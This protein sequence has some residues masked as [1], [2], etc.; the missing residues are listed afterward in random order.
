E[1]DAEDLHWSGHWDKL[2][3]DSENANNIPEKWETDNI[4]AVNLPVLPQK[5]AQMGKMTVAQNISEKN[6]FNRT[7]GLCK[8]EKFDLLEHV[9]NEFADDESVLVD[10][11]SN[12]N[13]VLRKKPD[14]VIISSGIGFSVAYEAIDFLGLWNRIRL[15]KLGF[16]YPL[17]VH[18]L[19]ENIAD[20]EKILIVEDT[21]SFI[22]TEVRSIFV[23][24]DKKWFG[25]FNGIIDEID[26]LNPDSMVEILKKILNADSLENV[27]EIVPGKD[28]DSSEN[29]K[30][31]SELPKRDL[32]FCS[33]CPHK[34][35]YWVMKTVLEDIGAKYV[36]SGDVGCYTL[37]CL[38]AGFNLLQTLNCMGSSIGMGAGFSEIGRFKD[39]LAIS[40]IGDSTFMHSGL[41]ALI[42][43][44]INSSNVLI[45][46]LDNNY[47]A[48]TGGQKSALEYV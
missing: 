18:F 48:M 3:K 40:V 13:K 19:H 26:E 47:V 8:S 10:G 39:T 16:V 20:A 24:E 46:I 1:P 9:R 6:M 2:V 43:C 31:L 4:R 32:S 29:V 12:S 33:G 23:D 17:P 22:E 14:L 35:S 41:Q 44:K 37:G 30:I 28:A 5:R 27:E 21:S 7:F 25:R 45:V 11:E 34:A 36:I 38:D 42:D 15:V